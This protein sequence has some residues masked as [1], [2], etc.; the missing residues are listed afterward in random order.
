MNKKS[1]A[2]VSAKVFVLHHVEGAYV[3]SVCVQRRH[4][5]VGNMVHVHMHFII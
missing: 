4:V 5:G 3:L 1:L 2:I